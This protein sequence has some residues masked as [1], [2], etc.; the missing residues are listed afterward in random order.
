MRRA[1]I[2]NLQFSQ[3]VTRKSKIE[4]DFFEKKFGKRFPAQMSML[5]TK[6]NPIG[7]RLLEDN[8]TFEDQ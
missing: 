2:I 8:K 7:E 5:N 3:K 6:S 4:N 1:T